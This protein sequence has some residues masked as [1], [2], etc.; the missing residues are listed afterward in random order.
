MAIA[1]KYNEAKSQVGEA[2][3]F[4]E[5]GDFYEAM[6]DDAKL[7]SKL[8]GLTLVSRDRDG[9]IPMTGFPRHQLDAYANKLQAKGHSVAVG[10]MN[11]KS[12]KIGF[13]VIREK[14]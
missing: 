5:M 3:L 14:A 12:G 6:F 7:T 2:V 10:R 8:L 1:D 9:Q 4:F 13:E 11:D